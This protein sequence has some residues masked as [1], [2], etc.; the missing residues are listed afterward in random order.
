MSERP[1]F[2]IPIVYGD[3]T[4]AI[5]ALEK[6]TSCDRAFENAFRRWG[7]AEDGK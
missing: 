2:D 5:V 3:S 1:W 7:D 6:S 4:R